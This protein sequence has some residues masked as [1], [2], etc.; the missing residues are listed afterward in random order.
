[1]T[2]DMH[3]ADLS[4]LVEQAGLGTFALCGVSIGGLIAQGYARHAPQQL[5][6]LVL[7]NT[8][9]KIGTDEFWNARMQAVLESGV[10]PIADAIMTR[11]FSP[12]F[13]GSQ[14]AAWAAWRGNFL[15]NNAAGYAATCATL[16]DNDLTHALSSIDMP[17]LVFA[18]TADMATPPELVEATARQITG[19]QFHLFDGVGHLPSL[20]VPDQL[21]RHIR[22]FLEGAGHA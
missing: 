19:A 11:W 4:A 2:C 10:A 5:K 17:V 21:S 7:C 6:A 15:Q 9:A 3:L 22:A 14:S 8:A 18:G 13:A 16:R 1:M 20:E 12:D